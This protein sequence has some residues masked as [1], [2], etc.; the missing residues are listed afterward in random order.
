MTELEILQQK[1]SAFLKQ[2][3]VLKMQL[4]RLQK[5]QT[6]KD[7]LVQEQSNTIIELRQQLQQNKITEA[8]TTVNANEQLKQ[9]LD[10]VINAIDR[11]LD[12]LK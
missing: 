10:L 12:L 4:Q 11:N 6:K 7:L 5:E 2:H 9:Q 3:Q 1:L 8:V